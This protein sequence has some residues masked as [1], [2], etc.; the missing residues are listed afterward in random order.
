MPDADWWN[1]LWCNPDQIVDSILPPDQAVRNALDLCCGDG[2]FSTGIARHCLE[3]LYGIDLIE[4]LIVAARE[5]I[6]RANLADKCSFMVG[7]ALDLSQFLTNPLDFILIAN[8]FHGIPDKDQM[9]TTMKAVLSPS[10]SIAILNWHKRPR[11]ET[12]V[13]GAPRG[14]KTDMRMAP[15]DVEALFHKQ[16]FY[17]ARLVDIGAYHYAI[18]FKKTASG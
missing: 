5:R 3:K 4:D 14:P 8:T 1:E 6:A 7:D 18:V 15:E 10:G 16:G 17:M 13:L 2:L 11:E 9:I 12:T